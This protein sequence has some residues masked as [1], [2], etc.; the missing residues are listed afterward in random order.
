MGFLRDN[1]LSILLILIIAI[2]M[3]FDS[4]ILAALKEFKGRGGLLNDILVFLMPLVT[5][6]GHGSMIIITGIFLLALGKSLKRAR[7]LFVGKYMIIGF[8]AS[9]IGVQLI[10]HLFG[11]ARPRLTEDLVFIGPSFVSGFDSFPSGH[12]AV[13]FC[14]AFIFASINKRLA[15][16]LFAIALITGIERVYNMSHFP[17]DVAAGVLTGLIAALLIKRWKNYE[18]DYKSLRAQHMTSKEPSTDVS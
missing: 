1:W 18:D 3:P 10:K 8:L 4:M 11:R 13:V 12:T 15:P 6:L 2:L 17:S 14:L 16:L 7:I 9:G 5:F